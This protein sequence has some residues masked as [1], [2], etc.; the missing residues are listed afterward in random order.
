MAQLAATPAPFT[1]HGLHPQAPV[2][3]GPGKACAQRTRMRRTDKS[4]DAPTGWIARDRVRV[5]CPEPK[6]SRAP[7]ADLDQAL[8][9]LAARQGFRAQRGARVQ[10]HLAYA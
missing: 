7:A 9:K 5:T 3:F 6:C 1:I 8:A 10:R 4:P 2:L